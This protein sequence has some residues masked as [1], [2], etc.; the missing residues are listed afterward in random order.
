MRGEDENV[1][2]ILLADIHLTL[3]APVW[4][5]A[6]PDWLEAQ[7]RPLDEVKSL[8]KKY[9]CPI[10]CAGDVFDRWNCPVELVNWAI[11]NLPPIYAIPG[12]HDMP[13]HRYADLHRS[14]Y[15]TLIEVGRI[16]PIDFIMHESSEIFGFPFERNISVLKHHN[17]PPKLTIAIAHDYVWSGKHHYPNAPEEKRV[18]TRSNKFTGGKLYGYDVIVYG[19]NH[20]G[21]LVKVGKTTIFNC[22]TLMRRKSDEIDYKPQVGLLLDTGEVVPHYLDTSKDKHL[23]TIEEEIKPELDMKSF[24][25]EL[26]K[27]GETALDFRYAMKQFLHRKRPA[28]NEV[29]QII[30]SAMEGNSNDK[31]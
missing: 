13:L 18:E 24:I 27:L 3:K 20:D 4:R 7:R 9:N 12:Q 11:N 1:I 2:G 16:I 23:D 14:A 10:F 5:S 21:F 17:N 28:N 6:E 8:A 19:D 22:G 29:K 30:I 25:G 26:E 15:W 31:S